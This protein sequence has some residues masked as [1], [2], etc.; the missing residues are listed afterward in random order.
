MLLLLFSDV[1]HV[2]SSNDVCELKPIRTIFVDYFYGGRNG[3]HLYDSANG[4][5]CY[6]SDV[7]LNDLTC[8]S[9]V[10]GREHIWHAVSPTSSYGVVNDIVEIE[11]ACM[12]ICPAGNMM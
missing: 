1:K 9:V 10:E 5:I 12:K 4:S 2:E 11:I 6:R 3:S 8:L 7:C